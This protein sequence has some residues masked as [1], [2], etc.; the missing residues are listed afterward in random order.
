MAV[1]TVLVSASPNLLVYKMTAAGAETGTI[2]CAG[3]AT[4]DIQTDS[5]AGAIHAASRAFDDGYGQIGPAALT[6]AEALALLLG[7]PTDLA[8]RLPHAIAT[9]SPRSAITVSLDADVDGSG[10]PEL[11]VAFSGAGVC[12][13]YLSVAGSIGQ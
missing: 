4:P 8:G 6:Q 3:G 5:P 12:Y 13:L 2:P 10:E 11:N 1:T 9:V 7:D